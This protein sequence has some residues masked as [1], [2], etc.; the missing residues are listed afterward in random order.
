M[1]TKL[2]LTVAGFHILVACVPI[3][4]LLSLLRP[5]LH[6]LMFALF[7]GLLVGFLNL[8]GDEVQFP[9]LLLIAFGFFLAYKSPR[10]PWHLVPL[11]ALWVPLGEFLRHALVPGSG[12]FIH[13]VGGSAFA[14]I[15]ALLGTVLGYAVGKFFPGGS[16]KPA[17]GAARDAKSY[18]KH[19]EPLF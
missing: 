11:L 12:A 10:M 6:R 15:P 8:Q 14:F 16:T 1:S 19:Q 17:L 5:R 13:E 18:E 2:L 7:L 4:I 3:A 9:I